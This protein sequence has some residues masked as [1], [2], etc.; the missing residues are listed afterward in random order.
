M[1]EI[2]V[3]RIHAIVDFV[4]EGRVRLEEMEHF[5]SELRKAC[6]GLQGREIKIK[7]DVRGFRP[8]APEVAERIRAVQEFGLELGVMRV[9]EI[10]E[11]D[12]VALQLNRV[13]RESG[14]DKVLRR[15]WDEDA[16]HEWL[17]HGDPE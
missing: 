16:A 15:F 5:V 14:T 17:L 11:S 8:M 2:K 1:F 13:A 10:I 7:A 6:E 9:A 3:D 12:I 4:L